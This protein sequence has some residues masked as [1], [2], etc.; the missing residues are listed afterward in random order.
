M[1]PWYR[2]LSY[3]GELLGKDNSAGVAVG[4]SGMNRVINPVI[5]KLR[6][7]GALLLSGLVPALVNCV[8]PENPQF[9]VREIIQPPPGMVVI[10]SYGRSFQQ[11]AA[12]SLARSDER[13]VFS[14]VFAHDFGIDTAEVTIAEYQ[15]V[16]GRVPVQYGSAESYDKNLPVC[17]VT[18]F[19]AVLYCNRKSVLDGFDTVYNYLTI[20]TT[21][22]GS[23]CGIRGLTTDFSAWG[24]RLP[25]EGEWEFAAHG[26]SAGRYPWGDRSEDATAVRYAWYDFNSDNFP[27]PVAG[28]TKNGYGLYDVAGNAAE[29]VNDFKGAYPSGKT[30]DFI[31]AR[32][33]PGDYRPVKGGGF[34]KYP[35]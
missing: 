8:S 24:Y 11:G 17:Y 23:C 30:I 14:N 20:D 32:A 27:H 16:T 18:W 9:P 13:P 2:L 5:L 35:R 29:W 26:G 10:A 6:N 25:T 4:Y 28:L 31:G 1:L 15:R 33:S 3:D 19:D 12:D 34:S 21:S 7:L 22:W